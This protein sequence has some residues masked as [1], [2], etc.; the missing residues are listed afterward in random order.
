MFIVACGTLSQTASATS[1]DVLQRGW[2]PL[3]TGLL[4]LLEVQLQ[5]NCR[6]M[7]YSEAGS[8]YPQACSPCWRC[9]S[10]EIV[11][12]CSCGDEV[13]PGCGLVL[14]SSLA[15]AGSDDLERLG[16]PS[17]TVCGHLEPSLAGPCSP[18]LQQQ[19]EVQAAWFRQARKAVSASP[20]LPSTLAGDM[21]K[22]LALLQKHEGMR[23][24]QTA[25]LLAGCLLWAAKS[26]NMA[27]TLIEA[28]DYAGVNPDYSVELP[29][30]HADTFTCC[31]W[32]GLTPPLPYM[33]RQTEVRQRHQLGL[34]HWEQRWGAVRPGWDMYDD[35]FAA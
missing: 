29:A 27:L 5:R 6:R 19:S 10:S 28:C 35:I 17:D 3:P 4:P 20:R 33:A 31:S 18:P 23:A 7:C 34:P 32:D 26:R 12:D 21:V 30:D 2:Q 16:A 9:S 14:N 13:C 8:R 1:G 24:Y 15:V 25:A 11:V 22:Q